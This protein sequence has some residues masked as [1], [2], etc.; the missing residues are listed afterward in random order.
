VIPYRRHCSMPKP[1]E[2]LASPHFRPKEETHLHLCRPTILALEL[3]SASIHRCRKTGLATSLSH[4]RA[5]RSRRSSS[6]AVPEGS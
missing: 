6:Y 2:N 4:D 3:T 5:P 1:P